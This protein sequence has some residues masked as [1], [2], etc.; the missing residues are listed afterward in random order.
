MEINTGLNKI[1]SIYHLADIHFPKNITADENI[2]GRYESLVNNILNDMS[3]RSKTTVAI[4]A[5]DFFNNNDQGSP[6]LIEVAINFLNSVSSIMPVIIF[7]GNHDYNHTTHLTWFPILQ[8]AAN[9]NVHFLT[10][11]GFYILT[12]DSTRTLLGFQSI[13]DKYYSFFY[14]NQNV[15]E[16]KKQYKC[17]RAIG[18][19]HGN[20]TG[21]KIRQKTFTYDES[22]YDIDSPNSDYNINKS[23]MS[24]YDL[25]LLGHI[26]ERQKIEP[27]FYYAGSTV[28]RNFGESIDDHGGYLFNINTLKYKLINY[29]DIYANITLNEIDAKACTPLISTNKKYLLKIQHS[30]SLSVAER[31]NIE[32]FYRNNYNILSLN[33]AYR[34][35]DKV[36]Q[37]PVTNT[38]SVFNDS[39]KD[40]SEEVQEQLKDLHCSHNI[41]SVTNTGKGSIVLKKLKWKN[42][43][44]YG[45]NISEMIFNNDNIIT[46]ISAPNTSGKSTIWRIILVALYADSEQRGVVSK[47][48][49]N[50]VNKNAKEG[51]IE[52][53]CT[54]DGDECIIK[55]KFKVNNTRNTQSQLVSV[56]GIEKDKNWLKNNIIPYDVLVSNYSMTKDSESIYSKTVGKLQKYINDTFN[57]DA[58][59]DTLQ[60][61]TTE[62]NQESTDLTDKTA[63]KEVIQSKL[64]DLDEVNI[65]EIDKKIDKLNK[66]MKKLIKPVNKF[67]EYSNIHVNDG[68]I[69]N[70]IPSCDDYSSIVTFYK[71][72]KLTS[73][74]C[75]IAKEPEEVNKLVSRIDRSNRVKKWIETNNFAE[76]S[77][78]MKIERNDIVELCLK[79]IEKYKRFISDDIL[80]E[81][82][83]DPSLDEI[84]SYLSSNPDIPEETDGIDYP[85]PEV[86]PRIIMTVY[87]DIIDCT[88]LSNTTNIDPLTFKFIADIY[89]LYKQ[90][91]ANGCELQDNFDNI[92]NIELTS[93]TIGSIMKN[94]RLL[95]FKS[96][97]SLGDRKVYDDLE[98]ISKLLSETKP[99]NF[100]SLRKKDIV[101]KLQVC[102]NMLSNIKKDD[103]YLDALRN[104]DSDISL[105]YFNKLF[106]YC[107]VILSKYNREALK[108]NSIL[109][110]SHVIKLSRY[111]SILS[112]L[113]EQNKNIMYGAKKF[114]CSSEMYNEYNNLVDR[115]WNWC[116]DILYTVHCGYKSY[117]EEYEKYSSKRVELTSELSGLE[118]S[119]LHYMNDKSKYSNLLVTLTDKCN[120]IANSIDLKRK[121]KTSL[122]NTRV[123]IVK[124][125]LKSLESHIN[126][127]LESYINYHIVIDF[128]ED[129]NK[130]TKFN[131]NI[132]HSITGQNIIYD[133]LSGYEKAIVQFV[134]MHIINSFSSY[135][136]NIFYID[137]AFDVFDENNFNNNISHLL[138]IAADYS[139]NVLFVTHRTLPA[140]SSYTLRT[141]NVS[142]SGSMLA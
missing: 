63:R 138:Q 46:V 88:E 16:I 75:E 87:D 122:E 55:R 1:D 105:E 86:L 71:T 106:T 42:V 79:K 23:W 126:N 28:Q 100:A 69:V 111:Y 108:N 18:L 11:S 40:Y 53:Y 12:S 128:K 43:F 94:L 37:V 48:I 31:S 93:N 134:T 13:T 123:N 99:I 72:R 41:T 117:D 127:E 91:S 2:H 131:I 74:L 65:E 133:N 60:T 30:N 6:E 29:E 5:G 118:N 27:N 32:N 24:E 113:S 58:I 141:I 89:E 80:E 107:S 21:C 110:K 137:E 62:I 51:W 66:T 17:K 9:K 102:V 77:R 135:T 83:T 129:K 81:G 36:V 44:C 64:A 38:E 50:I 109:R 85:L 39:I 95:R 34:G 76:L 116:R 101:D 8:A 56:N 7:A 98:T 125:G 120:E 3:K 61:I 78:I 47:L 59:T 132:K 20:V 10:S 92:D 97:W 142:S 14:N 70:D 19:F 68:T 4:I 114:I 73:T 35:S 26:H 15:K 139:Q 115:L 49:D 52:L 112:E 82:D 124:N 22:V 136:F 130:A 103:K 67:S 54:I 119:K 121:Y 33:W 140:I 90:L 45:D 96:W 57:L 84:E 25:I 104:M